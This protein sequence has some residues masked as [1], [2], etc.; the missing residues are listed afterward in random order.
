MSNII[1]ALV[2]TLALA[3]SA[4]SVGECRHPGRLCRSLLQ[5]SL[6]RRQ[7]EILNF[8]V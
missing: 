3:V 7:S 5:G 6:N 4:A 1:V 2:F 8:S